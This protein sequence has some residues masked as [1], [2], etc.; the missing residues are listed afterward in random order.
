[1]EMLGVCGLALCAA[2]LSLLLSEIG[3]H[4]ARLIGICASV[5]ILIGA[6]GQTADILSL[7]TPLLSDSEIEEPIRLCLKIVGV[8]YTVGVCRDIV[9]EMGH[10]S[11]A[12]SLMTVGRAEI[13]MIAAPKIIE[14]VRLAASLI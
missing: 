12:G 9:E 14:V 1:M 3:Y 4:G 8:G 2:F 5:L 10:K 13:L 6:L 11:L 7:F